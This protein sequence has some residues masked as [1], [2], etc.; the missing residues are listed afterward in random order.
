MPKKIGVLLLCFVV[1][2]SG[3]SSSNK[4]AYK[5]EPEEELTEYQEEFNDFLKDQ[6]VETLES[7]YY[8]LHSYLKDPETY[9]IDSA[10]VEKTFGRMDA[11]SM[12]EDRKEIQKTL[13]Q[14]QA[15]DYEQLTDQQQDTYDI[16]TYNME[17]SKELSD[18]K[19]D[20]IAS[21]FSPMTGIHVSFPTIFADWTFDSEQ[22]LKDLILM[23]QDVDDY[24][25]SAIDYTYTQNE[26]G[27]LCLDFDSI[28]SYC[29]KIL[30]KGLE[31]SVLKGLQDQV[32]ALDLD[33]D[34]TKA[35][36]QE[37]EQ[38]F[39]DS[40]LQ[41]YQLIKTAMSDLK[42]NGN[43][44]PN[45]L[46]SFDVGKEYYSL[47]MKNNTGSDMEVIE[48]EDLMDTACKEHLQTFIENAD[49]DMSFLF[50]ST[51]YT[52]YEQMLDDI[53]DQMFDDFPKV[54]SLEYEIKDMEEDVASDNGVAAY[55]QIPEIDGDLK[56]QLRVNPNNN[57]MKAIDT[58]M[59]VA[60]EGMPGH[61]YQYNYAQEHISEPLRWSILA[62]S[63]YQEG[64]ATYAQHYS[65]R[66]LKGIKPKQLKAYSEY[67]LVIYDALVL[68]DIGIHY[69]NWDQ[70]KC[71]KEIE[72][73]YGI[74]IDEKQYKQLLYTPCAFEP[75]YTGYEQI[76][77]LKERAKNTLKS[78][79]NEKEFHT[80]LLNCGPVPFFIV[81][82]NMA[83]AWKA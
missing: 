5:E 58:Y 2:L 53:Q 67:M 46:A 50:T 8:T 35:Y 33:S 80:I 49:S 78:D 6:L 20:Y 72:E 22:E 71:Q 65:L 74:T 59:T 24:T 57:N 13:D 55:F 27:Y 81:E 64:Y 42:Q 44:H 82:E 56:G 4:T 25:Q 9:D 77:D 23:I 37:L 76:M 11:V 31:S 52:S 34:Q 10:S 41:A 38:A 39:S 66:Y 36:K 47:L 83:K 69:Y 45:G 70:E 15:F 19:F 48:V 12:E 68:A 18:P 16:F 29:E 3:C 14:L 32:D 21:A 61:M 73:N 43:N 60:H 40:Y 26:K 51:N 63:A 28:L 62:S 54:E 30:D 7:D 79:Y 1:L 75:Y 17:C